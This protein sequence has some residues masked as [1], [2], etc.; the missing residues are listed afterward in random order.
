M[1]SYEELKY[2][3]SKVYFWIPPLLILFCDCD[4]WNCYFSTQSRVH[5][6]SG[7]AYPA[8]FFRNIR[9]AINPKFE[10]TKFSVGLYVENNK[11]R[12]QSKEYYMNRKTSIEHLPTYFY[13]IH[14]DLRLHQK[15]Y[16]LQIIFS[17]NYLQD[18][19]Y[20]LMF[21]IFPAV[22]L[23]AENYTYTMLAVK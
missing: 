2:I 7:H 23:H 15:H 1:C 6:T 3:I 8:G 22:S 9:D 10:V 5:Y 17:T 12:S 4:Q 21:L 11:I 14:L 18:L 13:N 20:R 19:R 16:R